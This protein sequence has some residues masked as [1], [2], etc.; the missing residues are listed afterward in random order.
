[1][2][3]K[4]TMGLRRITGFKETMVPK[5]VMETV[6]A[7]EAEAKEAR[8]AVEVMTV[9]SA[10]ADMAAL[11]DEGGVECQAEEEGREEREDEVEGD[12]EGEVVDKIFTTS[13]HLPEMYELPF[14]G[15]IPQ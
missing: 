15:T 9:M 14:T 8:E 11:E 10:T 5:A 6:E 3:D 12:V 4:E 2:E 1:M 7:K 13:K